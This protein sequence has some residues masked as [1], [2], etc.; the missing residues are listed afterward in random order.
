MKCGQRVYGLAICNT[1]GSNLPISPNTRTGHY[2]LLLCQHRSRGT[3]FRA[4]FLARHSRTSS[5][6]WYARRNFVLSRMRHEQELQDIKSYYA[7]RLGFEIPTQTA[8]PIESINIIH[9]SHDAQSSN[10]EHASLTNGPLGERLVCEFVHSTQSCAVR[11][12]CVTPEKRQL[13]IDIGFDFDC[14]PCAFLHDNDDDR[15]ILDLYSLSSEPKE[16]SIDVGIREQKPTRTIGPQTKSLGRTA[17]SFAVRTMKT[18]SP[19]YL[20]Y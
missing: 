9:S 5:V 13:Y 11:I 4:G 6:P 8:L 14:N 17:T 19:Q 1:N 15:C 12:P 20:K 2:L 10:R 3:M 16:F 18:F 7:D